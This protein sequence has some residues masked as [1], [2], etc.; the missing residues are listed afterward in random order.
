MSAKKGLG[1]GLNALFGEAEREAEAKEYPAT[2]AMASPCVREWSNVLPAIILPSNS[3]PLL[4]HEL[5]GLCSV[6]KTV[7]RP[8]KPG[9]L[10]KGTPGSTEK[11]NPRVESVHTTWG[12]ATRWNPS[13]M[14]TLAVDFFASMAESSSDGKLSPPSF[15]ADTLKE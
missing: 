4:P 12:P 7:C 3:F 14:R 1:T 10:R 6:L 11:S 8:Q 9:L 2:V 13:M 15:T 5:L